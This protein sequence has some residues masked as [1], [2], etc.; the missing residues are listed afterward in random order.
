MPVCTLFNDNNKIT[1]TFL[2]QCK[3]ERKIISLAGLKYHQKSEPARPKSYIALDML[4]IK[5]AEQ[6][7]LFCLIQ[8]PSP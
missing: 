6:K 8:C 1:I 5:T 3:H 4:Q 7:Y 2:S